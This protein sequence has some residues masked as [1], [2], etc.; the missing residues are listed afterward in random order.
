MLPNMPL[1]VIQGLTI[2]LFNPF[3]KK[4]TGSQIVTPT[5]LKD[6]LRV[7]EEERVV[8]IK[9]AMKCYHKNAFV[10]TEERAERKV[11]QISEKHLQT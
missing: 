2:F 9:N 5:R 3:F 1:D 10:H 6:L 8:D 11:L 7:R 4:Y